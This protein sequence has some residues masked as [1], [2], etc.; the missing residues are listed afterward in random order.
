MPRYFPPNRNADPAAT[1]AGTAKHI[2]FAV[3]SQ[4]SLF[5]DFY[6]PAISSSPRTTCST[7][8]HCKSACNA[9]IPDA[10]SRPGRNGRHLLALARM[11]LPPE[12]P[13]RQSLRSSHHTLPESIPASRL[14]SQPS[15]Y[16]T[17]T[18]QRESAATPSPRATP[19]N[20]EPAEREKGEG[21]GLAR[22]LNHRQCSTTFRARK[23]VVCNVET[24]IVVLLRRRLTLR[25]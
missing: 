14:L 19:N 7:R 2:R 15:G 9:G 10:A 22:P 23:Y 11:C 20:P 6:L 25:G 21:C 12:R 13:F 8:K 17:S 16:S 18:I 24:T 5:S 4:S 3:L 1:R